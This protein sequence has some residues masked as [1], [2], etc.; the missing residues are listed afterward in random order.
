MQKKEHE[1]DPGYAPQFK[2][3]FHECKRSFSND[4]PPGLDGVVNEAG[5]NLNPRGSRGP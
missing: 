4:K 5:V 1:R 2:T 3:A